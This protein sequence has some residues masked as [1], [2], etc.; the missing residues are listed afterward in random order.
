[1][2]LPNI[3]CSKTYPEVPIDLL[4]LKIPVCEMP[5]DASQSKKADLSDTPDQSASVK[6]GP[7]GVWVRHRAIPFPTWRLWL[8]LLVP[9]ISLFLLA[10]LQLHDWLSVTER[11]PEA[12]FLI[13]EGWVPDY[14]LTAAVA[15]ANAA[16]ATRVF[17]TGIPVENGS[18][19]VEFKNYALIASLTLEK[20]GLP[21][22]V[23]RP[24]PGGEVKTERTRSMAMALKAVIGD[25]PVPESGRK[26]N[27][28]TKGTHARRSRAIFQEVLGPEWQVGVISVPSR[29]Y[30]PTKW[31]RQSEGAKTVIN[32]LSSLG[33]KAVGGI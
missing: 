33:L 6:A 13:V 7:R 29:S 4:P 2:K 18:H 11:V 28:I 10:G 14:V 31:Y 32:E 8:C 20:L 16:K 9:G 30:E 1:M 17:C 21:P 27:L 25:E 26:I 19:L 23:I 3:P 12:R 22:L 24:V 15:E 5:A